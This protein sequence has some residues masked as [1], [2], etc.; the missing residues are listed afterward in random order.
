MHLLFPQ[1]SAESLIKT[2]KETDNEEKR[3]SRSKPVKNICYKSVNS[4]WIM[5]STAGKKPN[6]EE[7]FC[8]IGKEL[9]NFQHQDSKTFLKCLLL[10]PVHAMDIM[11]EFR[12]EL[13]H[14]SKSTEH[15]IQ[16]NATMIIVN[17]QSEMVSEKKESKLISTG[18]VQH[19]S[20]CNHTPFKNRKQNS[21]DFEFERKENLVPTVLPAKDNWFR[22]AAKVANRRPFVFC[23]K[24]YLI[25][26]KYIFRDGNIKPELHFH[27][28]E[29]PFPPA[30]KTFENGKNFEH[31]RR[32][33][34]LIKGLKDGEL[35]LNNDLVESQIL[36]GSNICKRKQSTSTK[37]VKAN[38]KVREKK[39][40]ETLIN[41][42][43]DRWKAHK[44]AFQ[45]L[46]PEKMDQVA[47]NVEKQLEMLKPI[48]QRGRP[49]K[50]GNENKPLKS[51]KKKSE[52]ISTSKKS[53]KEL[54]QDCKQR[55][56]T[57]AKLESTCK[58]RIIHKNG[59]E[60]I[61]EL[62]GEEMKKLQ[63][64]KHSKVVESEK[65]GKAAKD[66]DKSLKDM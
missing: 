59:S 65:Y 60:Q 9:E 12:D 13:N 4:Q 10:K 3:S 2:L 41:Y 15:D 19:D 6:H 61:I 27:D 46:L 58:L 50:S 18:Q 36:K 49:F 25:K 24:N 21:V 31:R 7:D 16:N 44:K 43:R 51:C 62:N 66:K 53:V 64:S 37:K 33:N 57:E 38:V 56:S 5:F 14:N 35:M 17:K 20:G 34:K 47:A 29:E 22:Q 48:R 39:K 55:N 63:P 26:D 8:E 40:Y 32:L 30:S 54:Q 1:R 23:N 11:K 52:V 42:Q 28:S 45:E